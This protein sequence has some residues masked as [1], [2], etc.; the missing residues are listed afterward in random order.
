MTTTT[1]DQQEESLAQIEALAAA[2][3]PLV[4]LAVPSLA[5]A[6]AL[7]PLRAAM[8]TRG[9]SVPLI[10]DV[11]FNPRA[12]YEAVRHVAKIRI[13]PGNFARDSEQARML[14]VPLLD[15]LRHHGV[16]LRIGVNHG[17]LAPQIAD[18]YG[19]GPRG[20]VA[21]ALEYL[22]ICREV[23]FEDVVVALKASNPVLMV[24]ANRL[25]V[26]QL[27]DEQMDYP[28][29]LGVT[30]AGEGA[31]GILRATIGIATLL[32]EGI[33][34]TL[35]V[36]L[37][38]NPVD[39]IPVCQDI[40][41]ALRGREEPP[42]RRAGK[43]GRAGRTGTEWVSQTTRAGRSAGGRAAVPALA[44]SPPESTNQSHAQ[45]WRQLRVG[46]REPPRVEAR[47]DLD[48]PSDPAA[49]LPTVR[50]AV[51]DDRFRPE[52]WVA[53]IGRLRS[54]REASHAQRALAL[55]RECI[56]S[57]P[58]WAEVTDVPT[59]ARI[60]WP[61]SG[62]RRLGSG[63]WLPFSRAWRSDSIGTSPE[64]TPRSPGAFGPSGRIGLTAW[65]AG[66]RRSADMELPSPG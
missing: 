10:A 26:M 2:G 54:D 6:E 40:L 38:G 5:A 33:G 63:S 15:L 52:S 22:R 37:T 41:E 57:A 19:H 39:E 46:G 23:G 53:S 48:L 50:A 11:H 43:P 28:I 62:S 16:A 20:M 56:G 65:V 1:P 34:D 14:L 49:G 35:R 12:A 45:A 25:L 30:E 36:S 9:L 17:S 64:R 47:V 66:P 7:G 59:L 8:R 51:S 55:L 27:R 60:S 21:S 61:R 4:R 31:E 42:T 24:E 44:P 32:R 58:L 3:C 18:T 13:N 29:H